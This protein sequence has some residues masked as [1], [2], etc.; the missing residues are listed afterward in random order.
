MKNKKKTPKNNG[1]PYKK[2]IT[3]HN[4]Q[5]LDFAFNH[6]ETV[7]YDSYIRLEDLD[8]LETVDYNNDTLITDLVTIKKTWNN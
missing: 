7:D 2:P 5:A 4:L 3:K 6:L 1:K 8:A